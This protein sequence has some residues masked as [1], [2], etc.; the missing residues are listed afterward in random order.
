[1]WLWPV[2]FHDG[3]ARS[4]AC[5]LG[6]Q[7]SHSQ[8]ILTV[9]STRHAWSALA[10]MAC[11][12]VWR[13]QLGSRRMSYV[14]GVGVSMKTRSGAPAV[15]PCRGRHRSRSKHDSSRQSLGSPMPSSEPS[16]GSLGDGGGGCGTSV[17]R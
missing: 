14:F 3:M 6:S 9:G 8:L 2:R 12:Q 13:K 7:T 4:W 17:S 15:S 10:T 16:R 1:M 11:C 5:V